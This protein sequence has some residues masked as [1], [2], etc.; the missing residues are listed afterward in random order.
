[1][2]RCFNGAGANCCRKEMQW[3]KHEPKHLDV[4]LWENQPTT[5]AQPIADLQG[6]K[7][8]RLKEK[9]FGD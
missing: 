5:D 9:H 6:Q 2:R 3:G 8:A 7:L 4:S 1:M